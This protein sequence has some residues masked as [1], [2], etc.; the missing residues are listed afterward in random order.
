MRATSLGRTRRIAYRFGT[1]ASAS[2]S[3]RQRG[4]SMPTITTMVDA[5]RA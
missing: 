2:I 4:S 5:G 3:T 1:T